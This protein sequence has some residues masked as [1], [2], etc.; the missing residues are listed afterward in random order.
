MG[1]AGV[2]GSFVQQVNPLKCGKAT[3]GV[4]MG[5][6]S[7]RHRTLAVAVAACL[8]VTSGSLPSKA[9][10]SWTPSFQEFEPSIQ[11]AYD[12]GYHNVLIR[13]E[14]SQ[15][16]SK[17]SYSLA[18]GSKS[19]PENLFTCFDLGEDLDCGT[20][21][22]GF[23]SGAAILPPCKA[24]VENCIEKVWV[25]QGSS[26]VEAAF[27]KSLAGQTSVGY[28]AKG[29][30]AGS[31]VSIWSSGTQHSGGSGNYAV[32]P[33]LSFAISGN[34]I[35]IDR[36]TVNV[37][38]VREVAAQGAIAPEFSICKGPRRV[39]D[40]GECL[41]NGNFQGNVNCAYTQT[42]VCGVAQ[43]FAENTRVGVQLRLSNKVSGWFHGRLKSPNFA[44]SRIDS[45]YNRVTVDASPA[46]VSRF[47]TQT[48]PDQGHPIL[49]EVLGRSNLG[50]GGQFTIFESTRPDAMTVIRTLRDV[51]KDTAAGLSTV[52]SVSSMS[53]NQATYSGSQCLSDTS[54]LLGIVTTNATVYSGKAPEFRNGFLSYQV[55]GMHYVPGGTELSQGSYD[56]VLRSDVARC[57]YGF[58]RAPLSA[59]VS[60]VNNEGQRS[61]ATT[62]VSEKN[63][64]LKMAAYGFTFSEKTIKVKI[65]KAKK[66]KNPKKGR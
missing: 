8:A 6:W 17:G 64:W 30:P 40:V 45:M 60:V 3:L 15:N 19:T 21:K 32:I 59:S 44:V 61:F 41:D 14:A 66:V 38:P 50:S 12:R 54:R 42:N 55:A 24:T 7:S 58:S 13:D 11:N 57:L 31:T 52:W 51:A 26:P 48:R 47:F 22:K 4:K 33:T 2:A 34:A 49:Q 43:N 65:K 39:D 16:G 28:P 37:I 20:G 18:P 27:V 62:V 5:F 9:Q 56:L 1:L 23:F 29:V 35:S 46:V 53:A 63:G 25:Y 10:D 36:F